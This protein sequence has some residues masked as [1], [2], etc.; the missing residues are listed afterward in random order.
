MAVRSSQG[1]NRAV[2][3]TQGGGG[4]TLI[5]SNIEDKQ[6]YFFIYSTMDLS[7]VQILGGTSCILT[8]VYWL[9]SRRKKFVVKGKV[10]L[11][12][13]ANSGLGKGWL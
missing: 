4:V 7:T 13:G 6:K 2:C 3:S 8:L 9:L 11:I 12:T 10:V 1:Q 5:H